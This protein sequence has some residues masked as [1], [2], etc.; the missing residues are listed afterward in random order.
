[1]NKNQIYCSNETQS[2]N[3]TE[4]HLEENNKKVKLTANILFSG[5]GCQERGFENSGLFDIE[6]LN[7]S[8]I[9]KE[10]VLTYAAIHCGMTNEMIEQYSDYPSREEM[11]KELSD[12]NLGYDPE[13]NKK[14]DWFK[15]AKRK[16]KDLEKYWL[17]N[18]LSKNLGDISRIKRLPYADFWTCSFPCTDISVAGKLKGLNP[19]SGTRSSLL[20]E[21]IRLLKNAKDEGN[22]PKYI[23]IENVKSL[24][25]KRF[26]DSFNSLVEILDKLCFNTYWSVIN[27]KNC[28][29]PQ[30][31]ERVF[32]IAIRKDIDSG[33]FTF[34]VPFDTGIRIKHILENDVDEKYY[35]S[36]DS[37]QKLL[38]QSLLSFCKD[39]KTVLVRQATKK[40]YIECEIGGVS[41]LSYPTSKLRRGRVQ[42]G[43]NICPTLS[44]SSGVY[45]IEGFDKTAQ[46][47]QV[48]QIRGRGSNPTPQT[49]RVYDVE[50]IC[51]T[52]DT[53]NTTPKILQIEHSEETQD[54]KFFRIRKLT[55]RER[56]RLMGLTFEDCDKAS[57]LGVADS[58]LCKQ[59]GNGIITNCCELLAEH[60][61]KAQYDNSFECSDEKFIKQIEGIN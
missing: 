38:D 30:N 53:F 12:I 39:G 33:K 3:D 22:L 21:N 32:L 49:G 44:T 52:L 16:N 42:D 26:I 59:A 18:K 47:N 14:F 7:T 5:I 8:D 58:Q 6:I 37:M 23:M 35:I 17:A 9:N 60:L 15:L 54:S 57:L 45:R 34:P 2:K 43:G 46:I 25:S 4:T 50:Y 24:V 27:G 11:A 40:G 56:F 31:R 48:C 61:Y 1:M 41:D 28:G 19:E 36:N 55:P 29:V 51:P 20:W 10:S 13:R